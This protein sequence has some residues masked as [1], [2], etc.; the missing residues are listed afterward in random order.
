[1]TIDDLGPFAAVLDVG[2]NVGLFAEGCRRAWPHASITSFEPVPALAKENRKRA[3]GRW[4]VEQSAVSSV[5]GTGLLRVCLTQPTASTMHEPGAMRQERFGQADQWEEIM[6]PTVT[7]DSWWARRGPTGRTLLK[8][9]VEGHELEVLRGARWLLREASTIVT[10]IL[11]VTQD[12]GFVTGQPT[13]P[14]LEDELYGAG[15]EF[16]GVLGVQETA[17]GEV[18][19]FDG[20]W[21]R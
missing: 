20:V 9:D 3:E 17:A 8:I 11:E 16:A 21:R 15:F 6:V 2:G 19:Q 5:E 7:L 13:L 14:E 10:V 18:V 12:A 4:W 1:M